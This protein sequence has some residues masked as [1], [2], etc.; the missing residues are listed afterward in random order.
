MEGVMRSWKESSIVGPIAYFLLQTDNE[1]YAPVA[2]TEK[3]AKDFF[4]HA[5]CVVALESIISYSQLSS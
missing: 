1:K 4:S 2:N 5:A 3:Y